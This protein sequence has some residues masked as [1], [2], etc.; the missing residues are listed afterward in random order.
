MNFTINYLPLVIREDIPRLDSTIRA[1]IQFAILK[2]LTAAP[3]VFGAPLRHSLKGHW[4][5]RVGE[6][7]VIF[8]IEGSFVH[9]VGIL[10]RSVT[11]IDM[12]KRL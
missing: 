1:Q 5:L 4:R 11:Y 3:H 2:K 9:I 6:Y 7:R 12:S 8:R 10:H